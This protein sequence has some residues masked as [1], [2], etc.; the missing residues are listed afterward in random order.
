MRWM[1]AGL[2]FAL[3]V[4]LAIATAA[5]RADNTR[6]R[7]RIQADIDRILDRMV[8]LDRLKVRV[9]EEAAPARLAAQIRA[10]LRQRQS[11]RTDEVAP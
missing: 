8:E 7:L 1:L 4:G 3:T 11:R 6:C 10:H 2:A 5:F 9:Q